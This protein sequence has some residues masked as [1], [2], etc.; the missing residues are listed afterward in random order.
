MAP[1]WP[2]TIT[3]QD[4]MKF[5]S[6]YTACLLLLVIAAGCRSADE[7]AGTEDLLGYREQQ[8]LLAKARPLQEFSLTPSFPF[9]NGVLYLGATLLEPNQTAVMQFDPGGMPIIEVRNASR[10]KPFTV[11]LDTASNASWMHFSCAQQNN[12]KFLSN[13][14]EVIPYFGSR[15]KAG[16]DAY[17]GIIPL[18]H[19]DRLSLNN[20]PLYIRMAKGAMEPAVYSSDKRRVDAV[21]GY[22]NMR[23]FAYI[24]FDLS[25]GMVRLSTST[26]YEA[27]E[28]RLMDKVPISSVCRDCLAVEGSIFGEPVPIVLDFAGDFAFARGDTR[29]PTTKQVELG[30]VV[31]LDVTNIVLASQDTYPR[32]GRRMLDKYIVT[33]CP[34]EGMVYFER[35]DMADTSR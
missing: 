21:L 24:Q 25:K 4:T 35:P 11:L 7:P 2:V 26:P 28:E 18:M 19:I 30:N 34:R 6:R 16:T 33:V 27:D 23:Q 20:T 8:L 32:A 22:D 1:L 13:N 14:G 9:G 29:E 17:A 10:R 15:S 31:Y 5:I 12:Y 3:E